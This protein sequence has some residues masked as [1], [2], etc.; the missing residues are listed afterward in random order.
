MKRLSLTIL[1][2]FLL[3]GCIFDPVFDTSSWDAY[4]KSLAAIKA[5][6]SNDDLRRLDVALNYLLVEGM[7]G[8]EA[9]GQPL[10]NMIQNAALANPNII[11]DRL[12]PRIDGRNAATVIADLSTRLNADISSAEARLQGAESR[13][14]SVEVLS[15]SYYWRRTGNFEQPVIE[16]AVRNEGTVPISRIYFNCVLITPNRS[17]PWARQQFVYDFKGGL[18][19]RQKLTLTLQVRNSQ[20]GDLQLK[21]LVNTELKVVIINFEDANGVKMIVVDRER[22]GLERKVQASLQ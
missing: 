16:F 13:A 5:E 19:P 9:S 2:C 17:I 14:D 6:L 11:L 15:P 22:L 1:C 8:I 20:W 3:S 4:Q 10:N 12:R 21:D 7:P 18:E